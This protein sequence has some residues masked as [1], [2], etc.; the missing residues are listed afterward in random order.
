MKSEG[1]HRERELSV[2]VTFMR[3]LMDQAPECPKCKRLRRTEHEQQAKGCT[4][5]GRWQFAY[6]LSYR[7]FH[8][9]VYR[10]RG[11][12]NCVEG[13]WCRD[14]VEGPDGQACSYFCHVHRPGEPCP[15]GF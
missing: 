6:Q 12:V 2:L 7:E 1:K 15:G 13:A 9:A 8:D 3:S 4:R 14:F 5:C 11:C 10:H